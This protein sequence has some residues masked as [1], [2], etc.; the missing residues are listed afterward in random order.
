MF[1]FHEDN[2]ARGDERSN[3]ADGGKGGDEDRTNRS[4]DER[5]LQQCFALFIF[6]D[7]TAS[8]S[9]LEKVFHFAKEFIAIH[10]EFFMT[11]RHRER[12]KE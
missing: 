12:K 2:G 3:R 7:N 9:A 6:N 4:Q 10:T 11:S 1:V 8:L 5:N